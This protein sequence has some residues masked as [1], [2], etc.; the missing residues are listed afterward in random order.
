MR[1]IR[2]SP[3]GTQL[4]RHGCRVSMPRAKVEPS[5]GFGPT[6]ETWLR[7][8]PATPRTPSCS[9][10][11]GRARPSGSP[12]RS[13]RPGASTARRGSLRWLDEYAGQLDT[14]AFVNVRREGGFAVIAN[15]GPPPLTFTEGAVI[16][17]ASSDLD[18][19][20]AVATDRTVWVQL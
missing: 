18:A 9:R 15:L 7:S 3:Q 4:G 12:A 17:L 20:D 14:V 13:S 6:T 16:V 19:G 10:S 5:V 8:S 1:T 11:D 2:N